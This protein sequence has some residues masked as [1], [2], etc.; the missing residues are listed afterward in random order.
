MFVVVIIV[1]A[2]SEVSAK[3]ALLCMQFTTTAAAADI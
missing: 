1:I 3:I 2:T